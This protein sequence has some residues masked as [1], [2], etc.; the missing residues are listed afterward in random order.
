MIRILCLFYLFFVYS[1]HAATFVN[2]EEDFF[3][4]M[5]NHVQN[6]RV[7]ADSLLDLA[8]KDP[9]VRSSLGL[10][11]GEKVTPELRKLTQEFLGVHDASKINTSKEFLQR[12]HAQEPL[13]KELYAIYGKTFAQMTE[14]EKSIIQNLINGTDAKERDRFIQS[15]KPTAQQMKFM[16]QVEKLADGVERGS[17]P[18]T[19]EEMA[20]KVL[21]MTEMQ[22]KDLAKAATPEEVAQIK[23]KIKISKTLEELYPK[24]TTGYFEYRD[25]VAKFKDILKNA[26]VMTDYLD[27]YSLYQMIGDYEDARG[28]AFLKSNDLKALENDYKKFLFENDDQLRK[29]Q[30]M[31]KSTSTIEGLMMLDFGKIEHAKIN[32]IPYQSRYTKIF[33]TLEGECAK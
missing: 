3:I 14:E 10:A 21:T 19:N 25:K 32:K 31:V 29:V 27:K 23:K 20:K 26:G 18:V 2:S 11:P 28:K 17:N 5:K 24:V 16:D 33:E 12:Y 13:I 1:L 6:V 30:N 7:L 9:E 8:E 15:K 4:H 22:E